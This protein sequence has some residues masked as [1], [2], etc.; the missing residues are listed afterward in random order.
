MD[1]TLDKLNANEP[2]KKKKT[3]CRNFLSICA[4]VLN[5]QYIV[6]CLAKSMPQLQNA[7]TIYPNM[8]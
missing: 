1:F 7:A 3:T 4:I 8:F 5:V 6:Y 2:T